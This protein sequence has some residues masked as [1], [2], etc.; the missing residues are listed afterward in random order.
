MRW[1]YHSSLYYLDLRWGLRLCYSQNLYSYLYLYVCVREVLVGEVVLVT[2][3][4]FEMFV[5]TELVN[6]GY[7]LE[8][9]A[10]PLY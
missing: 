9:L 5:E 3:S 6:L 7:L 4:D 10:P 1:P 8:L 2:V